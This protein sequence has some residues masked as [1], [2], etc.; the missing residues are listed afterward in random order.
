M[1]LVLAGNPNSGKT[2]LFNFLTGS[3]QHVGNWPGVTV[4][5][6]EGII[7]IGG[8][9]HTLVDLPGIYTLD[10]DTIEQKLTRDYIF[11][12]K[13]D[14]IIN[15]LDATNLQRNLFFTLQLRESGVPIVVALNM[16]DEVKKQGI[17]IDTRKL[18]AIL[19]APVVGISAAKGTGIDQLYSTINDFKENKI[20]IKPFCT[21]CKNCSKCSS[22]EE[23]YRVIDSI[24][25]TCVKNQNKDKNS[26]ISEKIDKIVLNRYLAFPV[27]FIIMFLVFSLT[28]GSLVS[29]LSD[30]INYFLNTMLSGSIEYGLHSLHVSGLL[31]SLICTGI[32]P[33]IGT[34][35]SF[36]P[37]IAVLFILMSFLEDSGY[38]ARA[39]IMMDRVLSSF[40]LSGSS[41]IPLIMGFGCTVPAVMACRILPTEKDRRL[42]VLLT[43]FVSC[44]ARLPIYALLAGIF[45]TRYQGAVVFSIYIIGILVAV[46][47]ALVL[48]KTVLKKSSASFVMEVPPYR[49]PTVRNLIMHTW[50]KVK[51]FIVKAGTVMFAA[52]VIIW[53]LQSFTPSFQL[54]QDSNVSIISYIGRFIAPV[55]QPLGFGNWKAATALLTGVAAKEML[56]ST[57]SVLS[58]SRGSIAVLHHAMGQLFTPL[59]A[60]AFMVFVLLYSPCISAI[61]TMRK[62]FNSAKWTLGTLALDLSVAWV[63]SFVIYNVGRLLGL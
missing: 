20:E 31:I 23:R 39:A 18:S 42:T 36:L 60:F 17:E 58:A 33:G 56:V 24:I 47:A 9:K 26:G 21:G 45:F 6:K 19:G 44:S 3:K 57:F 48:N 16:M 28:F 53:F 55:L 46:I 38:M 14:L 40:G 4:E 22:G 30:A 35:L 11:K 59:S 34:V 7:N 49:L 12:N 32:I 63:V 13:P 2:S 62:E 54:T 61:A 41:F 25:A 37:Q 10:P 43:S 51:G 1:E 5:K 50:E 52:S 29:R 15:I 27:F 8:I